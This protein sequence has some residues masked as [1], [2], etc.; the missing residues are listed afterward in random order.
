MAK[1]KKTTP[2]TEPNLFTEAEKKG[3][4]PVKEPK[5]TKKSSVPEIEIETADS[6]DL[7][8]AIDT[9]QTALG[10]LREKAD[11]KV[12]AEAFDRFVDE[13]F[14][15]KKKPDNFRAI[16]K[17]STGMIQL[18][19][20]M[21]SSVLDA[22]ELMVLEAYDIP[23]EKKVTKDIKERFFFNEELLEDP[24]VVEKISKAL[25]TIPEL[26]GKEIIKKQEKQYEVAKVVGE[27]TLEAAFHV[28]N[29]KI[30]GEVLEIV[31]T[32]ALKPTLSEEVSTPTA[33]EVVLNH[34]LEDLEDDED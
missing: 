2:K 15:F 27:E 12:M 18:K 6:L 3:V 17:T 1:L 28:R 26:A 34:F 8:A 33:V 22:N 30:L 20:R 19:K 21:S 29:R 11:A 5:K 23:V 7:V 24:T 16:G 9:V 13:G 4:T 31:T 14:S 32:M 10:K 25:S